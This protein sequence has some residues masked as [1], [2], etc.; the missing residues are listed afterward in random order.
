MAE[1]FKIEVSRNFKETPFSPLMTKEAKLQVERKVVEVLGDLYGTYN[2][3]HKLNDAD[4][5]WLQSAGVDAQNKSNEL[6]AGGINDDWPVGRGIFIQDKKDFL[7]LVNFEEHLKIITLP[8]KT[9]PQDGLLQGIHRTIKLLQTFDKLGYASDPYLG[10]L[11]VSP[12]MLGTAMKMS[13]TLG[14]NSSADIDQQLSQQLV[15]ERNIKYQNLGNGKYYL[16]TQ[17]TLA[18]NFNEMSQ[19]KEFIDSIYSVA[20]FL[21]PSCKV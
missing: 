2:Q 6:D 3:I 16:E 10:S 7:V 14:L 20:A 21:D 1:D 19:I 5:E 17:Q 9:N 18:Q 11:T 12:K 13:C 8:D 4:V 15:H